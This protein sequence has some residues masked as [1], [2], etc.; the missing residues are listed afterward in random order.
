MGLAILSLRSA[1]AGVWNAANNSMAPSM[2]QVVWNVRVNGKLLLPSPLYWQLRQTSLPSSRI[3]GGQ[4]V[5]ASGQADHYGRVAFLVV[6]P[7]F[8]RFD[9]EW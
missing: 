4:F 9:S 1:S 3:D 8:L 6:V 2:K 5:S 7:L